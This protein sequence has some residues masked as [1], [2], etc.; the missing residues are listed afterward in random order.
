[1]SEF[2]FNFKMG[3][4]KSKNYERDMK[5]TI[6]P[7]KIILPTFVDLKNKIRQVFCQ[8]HNDCVANGTSN[9]ISSISENKLNYTPSRLFLYYNA[10]LLEGNSAEL[11]DE[12]TTIRDSMKAIAKFNFVDENE[13]GY[14]DKFVLRPPPNEIYKSKSKPLFYSIL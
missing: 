14:N 1:M 4:K 5:Y 13:Y 9:L 6:P 12:G 2:K 11:L 3:W 7:N 10:R 8:S